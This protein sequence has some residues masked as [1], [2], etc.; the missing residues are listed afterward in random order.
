[1]QIRAVTSLARV[2][3]LPQED[4][5]LGHPARVI[6]VVEAVRPAQTGAELLKMAG[7]ALGDLPGVA[8]DLGGGDI[9]VGVDLS[10]P[11]RM[12]AA[13]A[14][15]T[16]YAAV[17]IAETVDLAG[18]FGEPLIGGDEGSGRRIGGIIG[19]GADEAGSQV[20]KG[21][22]GVAGLALGQVHPGPSLGPGGA[23]VH[24]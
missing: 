11:F 19:L 18:I 23:Q 2:A 14:G 20:I 17:G 4:A 8:L 15:C 13:V 1:M 21:V 16:G 24:H 10:R 6:D 22:P 3:I 9:V 5:V 12:G 7:A